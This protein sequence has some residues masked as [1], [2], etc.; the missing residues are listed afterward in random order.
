MI[1]ILLLIILAVPAL[2]GQC[3]QILGSPTLPRIQGYIQETETKEPISGV[4]L[5]MVRLHP[6]GS[7]AEVV[8]TRTT[9]DKGY[10][11]F[12]RSKDQVY[13]IRIH[14]PNRKLQPL[15]IRQGGIGMRTD[16]GLMNFLFLVDKSD[17]IAIQLAR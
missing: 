9:N 8:D 10:F 12:K 15:S 5:E 1:R 4:K 3:Q 2:F 14:V 16:G 13:R 17:C 7:E 6:D 11:R